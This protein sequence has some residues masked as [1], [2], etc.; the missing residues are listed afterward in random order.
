MSR[1]TNNKILVGGSNKKKMSEKHGWYSEVKT[2][3]Q[4]MLLVKYY[5]LFY[6]SESRNDLYSLKLKS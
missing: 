3:K 2:G 1:L 6:N 4:T 5:M